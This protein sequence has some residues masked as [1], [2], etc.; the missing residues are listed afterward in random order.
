MTQVQ[1]A[2][3]LEAMVL[4]NYQNYRYAKEWKFAILSVYTN[5]HRWLMG[6]PT[7]LNGLDIP[8]KSRFTIPCPKCGRQLVIF[9]LG[10]DGKKVSMNCPFC[11]V[12]LGIAQINRLIAVVKGKNSSPQKIKL[13]T[14]NTK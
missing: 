14:R 13:Q 10:K 9:S 11:S 7:G 8:P 3:G 12:R 6:L 2:T 4:E 1:G 5:S